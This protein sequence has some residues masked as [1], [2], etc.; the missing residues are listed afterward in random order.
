[1][2]KPELQNEHRWLEQL[3]GEWTFEGD[4]DSEPGKPREKF[5]GTESVRSLDGVWVLCEGHGEAPGG[6]AS[7]TITTLGYDPLRKRF[8][9]TFVGSM[10]TH[11]WLYDGGLDAA[12]K[13]LTLDAEGPSF[14]AEGKMGKYRD[15]IEFRSEGHR[16]LTSSFLDDAGKWQEFM[17]AHYSRR[18]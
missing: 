10:M 15:T 17:T 2:K 6:E 4:G 9:G 16:V 12:N 5:S 7:T 13:V 18:K 1:M 8:V 3:V 11:L 14:T